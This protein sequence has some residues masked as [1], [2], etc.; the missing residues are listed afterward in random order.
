[1][2]NSG[3]RKEGIGTIDVEEQMESDTAI[4]ALKPERSTNTPTCNQLATD[5]ISR[6][7]AI[8]AMWKAL[9][10]YEDLTEKQFMEHEELELEDWFQHRIFVQ[11]M[12]E[13]CMKS[14]ESLP[15]VEPVAKNATPV[16]DCISRQGVIDAIEGT[17]WYHINKKGE[18]VSGSASEHEAWYKHDDIMLILETI[19]S[20][21]V[22]PR[23]VCEDAISRQLAIEAIRS[24]R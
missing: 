1:M 19:P 12:H 14:V 17:D 8:E 18:M 24:V 3:L 13:E 7:A 21:P 15:P 2:G 11:R 9:Y 23:P 5:S 6:Q 4:E 22:E 20:P 16:E 10:A